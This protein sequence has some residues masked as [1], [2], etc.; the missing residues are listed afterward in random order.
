MHFVTDMI[1]I[2]EISKK[3]DF[4][5]PSWPIS[6]TSTLSRIRPAGITHI[7]VTYCTV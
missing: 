3:F 4:K 6:N 1:Y 2:L 7:R 5:Y